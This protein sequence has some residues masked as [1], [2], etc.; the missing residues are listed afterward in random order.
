MD[1]NKF[2][3][4]EMFLLE[5]WTTKFPSF[6]KVIARLQKNYVLTKFQLQ[7]IIKNEQESAPEFMTYKSMKFGTKFHK[8]IISWNWSSRY[9]IKFDGD[10]TSSTLCENNVPLTKLS[11]I[12]FL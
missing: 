12:T 4:L 9:F 1:V 5:N 10:G 6:S 8:L 3:S 11:L 2:Y 7:I